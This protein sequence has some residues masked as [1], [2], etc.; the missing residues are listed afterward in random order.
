MAETLASTVAMYSYTKVALGSTSN[1]RETF[2]LGTEFVGITAAVPQHLQL[3]LQGHGL[4][5]HLHTTERGQ[6]FKQP[7]FLIYLFPLVA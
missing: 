2:V 7:E 6:P 5:P 4:K 3:L 1:G